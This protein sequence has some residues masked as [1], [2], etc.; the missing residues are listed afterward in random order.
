MLLDSVSFDENPEEVEEEVEES[1]TAEADDEIAG[2]LFY[3]IMIILPIIIIFIRAANI[4]CS[5]WVNYLVY[6]YIESPDFYLRDIGA[7]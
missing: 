7:D 4:W 5:L 3:M 6:S 2:K 1:K